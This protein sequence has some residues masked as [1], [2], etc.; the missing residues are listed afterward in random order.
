M[1]WFSLGCI[2]LGVAFRWCLPTRATLE[3][4]CRWSSVLLCKV[5]R[6]YAQ[7]DNES[8]AV[9]AIPNRMGREAESFP[10][11]FKYFM[12]GNDELKHVA[13]TVVHNRQS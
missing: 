7:L 3:Y 4:A 2:L 10:T 11:K 6:T 13:V 1:L 5:K 12:L 9:W 8:Q